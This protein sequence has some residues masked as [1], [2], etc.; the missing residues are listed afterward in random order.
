MKITE[1][2]TSCIEEKDRLGLKAF[3]MSRLGDVVILAEKNGSG[4][5]RIMNLVKDAPE[6]YVVSL[7]L[8]GTENLQSSDIISFCPKDK[9][10]DGWKSLSH[11]DL[12]KVDYEITKPGC[13]NLFKYTIPFIH[14]VCQ[15][16]STATHPHFEDEYGF[17]QEWTGKFDRLNKNISSFLGTELR[18]DHDYDPILYDYP[19]KEAHLSDGQEVLLQVCAAITAQAANMS[20]CIFLLDEPENHL[21]P[22]IVIEFIEKIKSINANGQIWIATHSLAI[23]SH[24]NSDCIWYVEDGKAEWSGSSSENV[25]KGL[26]GKDEDIEKLR[27]FTDLPYQ[28]GAT[29]FSAQC[30]LPPA[31]AGTGANDPQFKQIKEIFKTQQSRGEKIKVLDYGAGRGRLISAFAEDGVIT[32]DY[33][34][35][36]AYDKFDDYKDCCIDNIKK[37]YGGEVENRY[38]DDPSKCSDKSFDIVLMCNVLH[39][40]EYK[41]WKDVFDYIGNILKSTGYLLIVEDNRIPTGELPN[42]DGFLVLNTEQLNILFEIDPPL[43]SEFIRDAYD[44]IKY[45]EKGRLMAHLISAE[46]M[47]N[48]K[49]E[50]VKAAIESLKEMSER[51]IKKLRA[52][53][54][55]GRDVYKKGMEYGFWLNQYANASLCSES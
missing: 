10:L 18:W 54:E 34:D 24:F 49:E 42:K 48:V 45:K 25:L 36:Y 4:K 29:S 2:D 43:S 46:Y 31:V 52:D 20:N 17:F 50:T 28:F 40:I 27:Q 7:K 6:K 38:F 32:N 47:K 39:E 14:N 11:D 1:F 8:N 3:K 9:G 51:K 33:L 16:N 35:Y 22:S 15:N 5:T 23:L 41:E 26:L 12:E 53:A 55:D 44:T 19:I 13:K 37:F 30:L 21:H